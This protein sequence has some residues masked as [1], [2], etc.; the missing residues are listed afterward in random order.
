MFNSDENT[1]VYKELCEVVVYFA[2]LA[3][4]LLPQTPYLPLLS[5][6]PADLSTVYS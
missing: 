6:F 2:E 3:T 5:L 1:S 4:Q